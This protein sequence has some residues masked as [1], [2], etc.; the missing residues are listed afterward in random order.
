MC[1]LTSPKIYCNHFI[2]RTRCDVPYSECKTTNHIPECVCKEGFNGNGTVSCVPDGF[3]EEKNGNWSNVQKL[4]NFNIQSFFHLGKH[5]RMFDEEY[6]EFSDGQKK[7][8]D[9]GAR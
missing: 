6:V 3:T 5:Y 9:M 1:T 7:C 8:N 4:S 2:F